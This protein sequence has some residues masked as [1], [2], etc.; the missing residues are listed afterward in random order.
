[1]LNRS[2]YKD[3]HGDQ[4]KKF[5]LS[6]LNATMYCLLGF[7]IAGQIGV[8]SVH[9]GISAGIGQYHK[10]LAVREALANF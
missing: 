10:G 5:L 2:F 3:G 8:N 6:V 9:C 1:M 4:F 7:I